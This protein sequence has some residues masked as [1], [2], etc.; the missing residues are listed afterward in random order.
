M[1]ALGLAAGLLTASCTA[2]SYDAPAQFPPTGKVTFSAKF[3]WELA[4][5]SRDVYFPQQQ[6][7][8]WCIPAASAISLQSTA[9]K[10]IAQST[11]AAEMHTSNTQGTKLEDALPILDHYANPHGYA[12]YIADNTTLAEQNAD[13]NYDLG[14]LHVAPIAPITVGEL[15]WNAQ[16][17]HANHVMAVVGFQPSTGEVDVD[18]SAT[19]QMYSLSS[20]EL[21]DAEQPLENHPGLHG[22]IVIGKTAL[23]TPTP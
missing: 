17:A 3:G 1:A 19:G 20:E 10:T 18:D 16:Y 21:F 23:S 8:E 7:A 11:L 13:L 9:G 14:V 6:G 2:N 4:N 5:A 15:F 12:Y 22:L